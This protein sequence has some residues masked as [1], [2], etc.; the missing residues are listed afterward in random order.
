MG[1]SK[2][3][4]KSAVFCTCCYSTMFYFM[5]INFVKKF[6]T[7]TWYEICYCHLFHM[8][9]WSVYC[10]YFQRRNLKYQIYIKAEQLKIK[11]MKFYMQ[12]LY[13]YNIL[14]ESKNKIVP[15]FET[16]F[17]FM[18]FNS[19]VIKGNMMEFFWPSCLLKWDIQDRRWGLPFL[20]FSRQKRLLLH[21]WRFLIS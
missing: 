14:T 19:W 16:R 4:N 17:N 20:Q 3:I 18:P 15:T 21:R 7:T 13:K 10:V 1:L 9:T 8:A 6:C 11:K 12:S 5:S 2:C